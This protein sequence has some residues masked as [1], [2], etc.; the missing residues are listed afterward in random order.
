MAEEK[1]LGSVARR[2]AATERVLV[3]EDEPL[4]IAI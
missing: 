3:V 4:S 2:L 1:R